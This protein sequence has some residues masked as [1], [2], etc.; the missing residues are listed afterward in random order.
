MSAR[1]QI[2]VIGDEQSV[3]DAFVK[4]LEETP[5]HV[6]TASS[7]D[8]GAQKARTRPFGL[9]FLDLALP[10]QDGVEALRALRVTDA[11]VPVYILTAFHGEFLDRLESAH[12]EG[13]CFQLVHKPVG[14]DAIREVVRAVFEGPVVVAG[15][16]R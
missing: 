12:S 3:C 10:G 9:I 6:E 13:L 8:E 2:L 1:R 11:D 7:G 15:G 4:A 14:Q 16:L 5:Y